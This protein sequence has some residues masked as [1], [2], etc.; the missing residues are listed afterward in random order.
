LGRIVSAV[1]EIEAGTGSS[2]LPLEDATVVLVN[3]RKRNWLTGGR[4]PSSRRVKRR[5]LDTCWSNLPLEDATVVL[6]N[7]RKRNWLTGGGE[8]S[9]RPVKRRRLD[10][11]VGD[12]ESPVSDEDDA[13]GGADAQGSDVDEEPAVDEP[14]QEEVDKEPAE[15]EPTEDEEIA[16]PHVDDLVDDDV[17]N[18]DHEGEEEVEVDEAAP[19]LRR[20]ARIASLVRL[21]YKET[22]TNK[23]RRTRP[24]L[25][26]K[27]KKN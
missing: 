10:T 26:R 20:S 13:M 3:V 4:E 24:F 19:T 5:R 6:V 17:T 2:K 25:A 15:E 22:R 1:D 7:V 16:P 18:H 14:N 21:S 11:S 12:E 27:V 23:T 9:S 8:P